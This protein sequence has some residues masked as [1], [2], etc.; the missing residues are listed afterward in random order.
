MTSSSSTVPPVDLEKL[1][2]RDFHPARVSRLIP[3]DLYQ[4]PTD[5]HDTSSS[6]PSGGRRNHNKGTKRGGGGGA[7]QPH[8][9]ERARAADVARH[10]TSRLVL[11]LV[12]QTP[13]FARHL[14][15]DANNA[16][17]ARTTR[18][19]L[20]SE[21]QPSPPPNTTTTHLDTSID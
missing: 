3:R 7:S 13:N 14:P 1:L 10:E 5:H 21:Y 12:S 16:T 4:R 17:S 19:M 6:G 9:P 8:P 15:K 18:N 11:S 20:L 2:S